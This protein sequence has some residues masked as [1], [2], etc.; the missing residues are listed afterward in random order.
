MSPQ[1]RLLLLL[2]T[3][4]ALGV[5]MWLLALPSSSAFA[6][7]TPRRAML[8]YSGYGFFCGLGFC[9]FSMIFADVFGRKCLGRINGIVAGLHTATA[10]LGPLAFGWSR[11]VSG[12]YRL[13]ILACLSVFTLATAVLALRQ[14][15]HAW[16]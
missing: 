12:S 16:N 5:E 10:G 2:K 15:R 1:Q 4:A 14:H 7:N 6:V 9:V 3:Y 8:W 13:A 11:D